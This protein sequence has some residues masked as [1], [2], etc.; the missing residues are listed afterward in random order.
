MVPPSV[1]R[2][3]PIPFNEGGRPNRTASVPAG[4]TSHL[5]A[6]SND[7]AFW[8]SR[9]IVAYLIA[10]H[11]PKKQS[12]AVGI[13]FDLINGSILPNWDQPTIDTDR[14]NVWSC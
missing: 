14:V 8:S 12:G 9:D 7:A 1:K 13:P 2:D 6:A 3:P 11:A 10:N 5:F 4:E